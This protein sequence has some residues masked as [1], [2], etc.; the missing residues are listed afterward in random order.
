MFL[1]IVYN[2]EGLPIITISRFP[3]EMVKN[4]L[5]KVRGTALAGPGFPP[6]LEEILNTAGEGATKSHKLTS[7]INKLGQT[8][9]WFAKINPVYPPYEHQKIGLDLLMKRPRMGVFWEP[10]LGKTYVCCSRVLLYRQQYPESLTLVLALRVNLSTWEKEMEI[11]SRGKEEFRVISGSNPKVRK[12]KLNKAIADKV[13]GIV[14]TYESARSSIEDLIT[15]KFSIIIA[16][17]CHKLQNPNSGIT[18]AALQLA[19]KSSY[20]YVLSGTPSKG[21]PTD[22][23]GAMR[24]LGEFV[25]PSFYAF[26]KKH[27]ITSPW[28][29][30]IVTGYRHLADINKLINSIGHVVKSDQAVDLPARIFQTVKILPHLDQKRVYNKLINHEEDSITIKGEELSVA[31][32]VV[33]LGKVAQVCAGFI[34]KSLKDPKVCDTC[35][36]MRAC[37]VAGV[38]PYTSKCSVVSKDPGRKIINIKSRLVDAALE[39]A[40]SHAANGKKVILWAKHAQTI[41]ELVKKSTK[42]PTFR[43]DSQTDNPGD[44]EQEFNNHKGPCFIVAQV[45]MGIGVTFK[46]PIMI[47]T[48]L[49]FALD[50]W[51]QS[52]DR[53][54]GIRAKGLGQILVQ[55]L[56]INGSVYE[57]IYRLLRSKVDIASLMVDRPECVTC[58]HTQKCLTNN[59]LPFSKACILDSSVKK[60]TIELTR[61]I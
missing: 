17:E 7:H 33:K 36:K 3:P 2:T 47:Y 31:P 40:E 9:D 13:A 12:K 10:G 51:L 16:D 32:S 42:I 15:K 58:P 35:P 38:Q 41:N 29:Q 18:K 20:R 11:H 34:Y 4:K 23:W 22:I 30:H 19:Q 43:Y 5:L 49:P 37:V 28:N 14:I 60:N 50:Q 25:V 39:L 57:D 46:A 26:K 45:Q 21:K 24:F 61:F 8:E 59:T 54:W 53:N 1:N 55:V 6:Y 52:L 48:E 44:V 27:V 56:V